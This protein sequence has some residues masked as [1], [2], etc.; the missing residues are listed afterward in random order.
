MLGIGPPNELSQYMP[1]QVEIAFKS[2]GSFESKEHRMAIR[3]RD[4]GICVLGVVLDNDGKGAW[5]VS[6]SAER[7]YNT[8]HLT[9]RCLKRVGLLS[10][11]GFEMGLE[12]ADV[13]IPVAAL[14][15]RNRLLIPF[16]V[17]RR[18]VLG[19]W[20]PDPAEEKVLHIRYSYQGKEAIVEIRGDDE[21]LVLM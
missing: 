18:Y 3:P 16:G 19:F 4:K 1:S 20:D 11:V 10:K 13:T 17:H 8:D 12:V 14:V 9:F 2:R 7:S 21:Q 6:S 15:D 5:T